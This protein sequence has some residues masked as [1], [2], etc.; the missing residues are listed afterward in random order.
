M[1]DNQ[2]A[3]SAPTLEEALAEIEGL[4]DQL[5]GSDLKVF[6]QNRELRQENGK[7][8]EEVTKLTEECVTQTFAVRGLEKAK[9][10]LEKQ[11]AEQTAKISELEK[12]IAEHQATIANQESQIA[13]LE[14]RASDLTDQLGLHRSQEIHLSQEL[15]R[16]ISTNAEEL[17]KLKADHNQELE[18]T[19]L[20][21]EQA[22]AEIERELAEKLAA[23]AR[24]VEGLEK[25][26]EQFKE[27]FL[28]QEFVA[29]AAPLEAEG[30]RAFRLL[31]SKMEGLLGFPGKTLVEQVFRHCGANETTNDPAVL[32]EAFEALQDTASKLVR[33][34][35]QEQELA[36]LLK[37][38]WQDLGLGSSEGTLQDPSADQSKEAAP[39]EPALSE[40]VPAETEPVSVAED[41]EAVAKQDDP[42]DPAPTEGAAEAEAPAE[43]AQAEAVAE[44]EAAAE[45]AQAECAA[46]SEAATEEA[47]SE[48]TAEPEAAAE[49]AQAESEA[50]P[51]VP[52]E[53]AAAAGLEVT[54]EPEAPAQEATI[55]AAESEA[56]EE[57]PTEAAAEP[58]APAQEFVAAEPEAA[59]EEA[60]AEAIA[61]PEAAEEA[62]VEAAAEPEAPAQEAPVEVDES[63]PQAAEEPQAPADIGAEETSTEESPE[64]GGATP[65]EEASV[66][67]APAEEV[68]VEG[69]P[70]ESSLPDSESVTEED[71]PAVVAAEPVE[72]PPMDSIDAALAEPSVEESPEPAAAQD[73]A[74]APAE[75]SDDEEEEEDDAEEDTDF[76]AAA[77]ALQNGDFAKAWPIFHRLRSSSPSEPTYLVGEIASLAGL[78]RYEEAYALGK[79]LSLEALEDS[80][81][82][83]KES[84]ESV[85]IGLADQT[86]SLLVRK[87]HLIEL[88][89]MVEDPERVLA[90]LDEAEEI[91]L[92]TPREGELSLLQANHRIAQDDVTEYLIEALSSLSDKPEIFA[93]MAQNLERYPELTPLREFVDRLLD[94]SR[95]E[96]LEAESGAKELITGDESLEDLLEE[97]DPGEEALVQ[98]FLE[99]LLPRSGVKVDLPSESFEDLLQESEP[100][101]FVGALRQALRSVDYTLFFDE[102]EVLSYDGDEH[103]L[104]RSSPEP[105]P[106]LL[107]GSDVD[108]V[109][110]EELRFL[111]LRELFSMH[112]RHSH[113]AHL[114]AQLDDKLRYTF[115]KT[116]LEIHK[117]AE[118][119]IPDDLLNQLGQLDT[120]AAE[121]GQDPEFRASLENGLNAIYQATES[122]SF[123]ELADFL[124]DG[125]LHKKWLDPL[126][127]GFAAKQTG[128]VVASFAIARD[129]LSADDFEALEEAGFQWLYHPENLERLRDLR[130]RLQR[131]W[132]MP[133]KALVADAEE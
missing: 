17:S 26:V 85:L 4:K 68:S 20:T 8:R 59:A 13:D 51:E 56:A 91:A 70:T 113:L 123:L 128:L 97:I 46:E 34:P 1:S 69:A 29:A 109:P 118:F 103:F 55:E 76:D 86:D 88:A 40:E 54:A 52:A 48:A 93:L 63:L 72:E 110:P 38:A 78:E 57:A 5:S 14:G 100:A 122:D 126:A 19:R 61:E 73:N 124:F 62:T 66:E 121:G 77:A 81:E 120:S 22:K 24:E 33:N 116:C 65:P 25:R 18:T 67:E 21:L 3:T 82:V 39:D 115:V 49:E 119:Q 89:E 117:E 37:S 50:E 32:E 47:Q 60:P 7:L 104:L 111:V 53:D 80:A 58:E 95:D 132:A 11:A 2:G 42:T 105:K 31:R 131:L 108:D 107:F 87:L 74:Q 30:G 41:G 102:I 79:G 27:E 83:Y 96:A 44:P 129:T 114:A 133:F 75:E 92:R 71:R 99:H 125:Q 16:T 43:V 84:F 6:T 90:F 9:A 112:R 36:S 98:V 35:E 127:D 106:T 10:K 23:K 45:E 64:S 130:F 15:E 94:S 28:S 12:K 101:A